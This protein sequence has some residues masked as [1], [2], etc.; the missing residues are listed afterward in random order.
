MQPHLEKLRI[1]L[2]IRRDIME[3]ELAPTGWKWVSPSGGLNLWL[4]LPDGLSVETI[5][6]ESIR[7]SV[8]FVPGSLFDPLREMHAWM[9]L[10]YSFVNETHLREGTRRLADIAKHFN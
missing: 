5:R 9:R 7:Q 2:Q 3:E 8:S 6:S 4:N 10:S 1:A